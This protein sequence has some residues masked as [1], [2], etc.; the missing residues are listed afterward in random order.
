MRRP[1]YRNQ[2]TVYTPDGHL[3]RL[4][5]ANRVP[6]IL[7]DS[8]KEARRYVELLALLRTGKIRNLERQR[9]FK[10]RVNEQ[11]VCTYVCDF[12]YMQGGRRIVEDVK[13]PMTRKLP[14]YLLKKKLLRATLGVE[15]QEV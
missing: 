5:P 14:I 8:L 13:S 11:L 6:G 10:I 1:K 12:L 2:K 15:I 3:V 7:F 4:D 9:R